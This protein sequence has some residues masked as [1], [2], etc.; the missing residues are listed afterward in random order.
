MPDGSKTN[1]FWLCFILCLWK[2]SWNTYT[3]WGFPFSHVRPHTCPPSEL[4]QSNQEC[5]RMY[6]PEGFGRVRGGR[7][8]KRW[9]FL[10]FTFHPLK[11]FILLKNPFTFPEISY[12]TV[13]GVHLLIHL[14]NTYWPFNH[15]LNTIADTGQRISA[16]VELGDGGKAVTFTQWQWF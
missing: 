15:L 9:A 16:Q 3:T 13:P 6:A 11:K 5:C 14:K 7:E 4:L 10:V 2:G 1:S 8:L 12:N